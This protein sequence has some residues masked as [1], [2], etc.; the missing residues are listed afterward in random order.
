MLD[1]FCCDRK[2]KKKTKTKTKKNTHSS[3]KILSLLMQHNVIMNCSFNYENFFIIL[4]G[5]RRKQMSFFASIFR[6]VVFL[7]VTVIIIERFNIHFSRITWLVATSVLKITVGHRTLTQCKNCPT[8]TNVC[9]T[10]CRTNFF[11]KQFFPQRC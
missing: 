5:I 7:I 3:S 6:N 8:K 4:L 10:F 2:E 9:L 11:K 1:V